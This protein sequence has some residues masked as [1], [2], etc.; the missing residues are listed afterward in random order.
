[1]SWGVHSYHRADIMVGG[2]RGSSTGYVSFPDDPQGFAIP[3]SIKDAGVSLYDYVCMRIN[4][5]INR[6]SWRRR[7]VFWGRYINHTGRG[8]LSR[9][10]ARFLHGK[11]CRILLVYNDVCNDQHG[12]SGC[13]EHWE[14]EEGRRRRRPIPVTGYRHGRISARH[15][16]DIARSLG[17]ADHGVRIYA[18]LEGWAVDVAWLRGWFDSMYRDRGFAGAGGLYGRVGAE[19]LHRSRRQQFWSYNVEQ[20]GREFQEGAPEIRED[21]LWGDWLDETFL[22]GLGAVRR[23]GHRT[24]TS[25]HRELRPD[26]A[27]GDTSIHIWSNMPRGSCSEADTVPSDFRGL[28]TVGGQTRTVVWQYGFECWKKINSS[29]NVVFSGI[30]MDLAR[31]EGLMGMWAPAP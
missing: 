17:A 9:D 6:E 23:T 13:V 29:G 14:D 1:M 10:E 16:C 22:P 4:A 24:D 25:D 27:F 11:G 8:N 18:D 20:A 31:P 30:D 28:E 26:A 15:A 7:P 5:D 3:R 21:G 2:P 12:R 19:H